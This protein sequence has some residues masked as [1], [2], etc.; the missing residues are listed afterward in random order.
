MPLVI[1]N[2]GRQRENCLQRWEIIGHFRYPK[3]EITYCR[4]IVELFWT[5]GFTTNRGH[6]KWILSISENFAGLQE[7]QKDI[8]DVLEEL[9]NFLTRI[10]VLPG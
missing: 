9:K 2:A 6:N 8:S 4:A 5:R 3:A 7:Q 1:H 10:S